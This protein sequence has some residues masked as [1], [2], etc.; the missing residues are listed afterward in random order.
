MQL[1]LPGDSNAAYFAVFDGHGTQRFATYCSKEL[2]KYLLADGSYG[3][4]CY[5][6]LWIVM[7]D[8]ICYACYN[9]PSWI[10]LIHGLCFASHTDDGNYEQALKSSFLSLDHKLHTGRG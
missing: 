7:N 1:P 6:F 4:S 2:H 5:C 8:I 10:V 3:I 9:K